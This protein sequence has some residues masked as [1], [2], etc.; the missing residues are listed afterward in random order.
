MDKATVIGIV[1]SYAF[2]LASLVTG[3]GVMT[4]VN[5]PSVLIVIGGTLGILFINFPMSDVLGTF[6]PLKK[7]FF[8]KS[9]NIDELIADLVEY[10]VKAR[11]NGILSLENSIEEM[12]GSLMKTG[13]QMVLDGE[14]PKTVKAILETDLE[15]REDRHKVAIA[16]F[17]SIGAYAPAMGMIGTLIGLVAM[18]KTM[19]DPSTIGPNMAVALITTFYGAIIANMFAL[20]ISGK[21][22]LRANEESLI[23]QIV[24]EGIMSIQQGDNPRIM[25]QKLHTFL[26]PR[27]RKSQ[28][29][30]S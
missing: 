21:L 2:V 22:A 23:G 20:P 29:D 30:K 16:I 27:K 8:H 12:D 28:F 1:V 25:E 11:R 24:I 13:L 10:S 14:D 19:Q 7:A 15:N 9:E 4:Y 6:G 26:P 18:L 17:D 5:M 3:A